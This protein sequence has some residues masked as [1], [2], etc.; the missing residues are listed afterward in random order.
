MNSIKDYQCNNIRE[1]RF[2]QLSTFSKEPLK[3]EANKLLLKDEASK[4][5]LN[6]RP[7]FITVM[8]LNIRWSEDIAANQ[9]VISHFDFI[10]AE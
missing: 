1:P 8:G 6:I 5:L 9:L 2:I 10:E 3:D 7:E 4:L